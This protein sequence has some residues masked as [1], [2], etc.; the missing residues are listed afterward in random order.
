[1]FK[2]TKTI[3]KIVHNSSLSEKIKNLLQSRGLNIRV[4]NT[5]NKY[6][7]IEVSFGRN[8]FRNLLIWNKEISDEN[9][10]LDLYTIASKFVKDEYEIFDDLKQEFSCFYADNINIKANQ[11]DLFVHYLNGRMYDFKERAIEENHKSFNHCINRILN[12][13]GITHQEF[14]SLI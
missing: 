3:E 14:E 5:T 4:I 12:N 6:S 2:T 13:Y 11:K 10:Y 9:D 7:T 8:F 1:M